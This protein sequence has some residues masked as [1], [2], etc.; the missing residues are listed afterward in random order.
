[1]FSIAHLSD[2]ERMFFV[3]L[4]LSQVLGWTRAQTGTTSLRALVYMDEIF[5]YFPPTAN[6]PS[7]G[8]LLTLL[9]QARA[10]GVGVVLATQN[11]VDLDY[12]G[13]SNAG[14]WFIGRLQTERDKMRVL[15]GLEG[16][17]AGGGGFDRGNMERVLAG[18]GSR[19]FLMHNVHEDGPVVFESR[20]AMSYLRGPLTRPQI[21]QLMSGRGQ[22]GEGERAVDPEASGE[23]G[24]RPV[25][26]AGE[27]FVPV[28]SLQPAGSSLVYR[29][30]VYADVGIFYAD[31]KTG[32]DLRREVRYMAPLP[33]GQGVMDWG[34]AEEIDVAPGDLEAEAVEEAAF[35]ALAAE[36]VRGKVH[37]EWKKGLAEH[38]YR[39]A[40]VEILRSP[41]FGRSSMPGESERDYRVRL[42][43]DAREARDTAAEKLRAKYAPKLAALQERIRRAEAAVAVQQEQAKSSKMNAYIS[44]GSTLL[45]AFLGRKVVS[46]GNIGKAASTARGV[47]RTMKESQ[48]VARAQENVAA[49]REQLGE[50]ERAFEEEMAELATRFDAGAEALERVAMRP[51]KTDIQV[52]RVALAWMPYWRTGAGEV[53]AWR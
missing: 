49:V 22:A 12:K 41:T 13:L 6:P 17:A 26:A 10:F 35:G 19:V 51:K 43:Q 3:S 36:A 15:D 42:Q 31:G 40:K 9:K 20:W 52:R 27:V 14:T 44:A 7:K 23:S 37:E 48:D 11:P 34:A 28:R 38:L 2:A 46:A 4:L 30:R 45:G 39:T 50:L 21:K 1:V 8:P 5:G 18:L 16:A 29:P 25:T 32:A 53:Q 47:G 33:E 24:A